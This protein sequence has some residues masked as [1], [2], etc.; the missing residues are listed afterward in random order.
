MNVTPIKTRIF[1]E[2]E[3]LAAFV[4]AQV[5]RLTDGMI[6]AVSS[7]IVALAEG[8]VAEVKDKEKLVKE[9]SSWR[10]KIFGSWWLT[11][12]D[13]TVVVNAGIDDSNA[14]GKIIL[15]P[16]DCFAAAQKLR[17][18]LKKHYRVERLGVILT[19]SRVSPLRA[20][21]TGVAVG[22]AGFKGARDYRGTKDIFGRK[23]GVTQTNV[24]DN[25][26]SAAVLVTGEGSEQCPIALIEDA[27]VEFAERVSRRELQ[28]PLDQDMYRDLFKRR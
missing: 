21:V 16:R 9:E 4:Y 25:L 2:G 11:V 20:G 7:K 15:L 17:V 26:A 10:K 1:T 8:R 19:D 12:R 27:P 24:A 3:D 22:Y 13:G 18:A 23:L 5:P 28:I 6:V 14:N